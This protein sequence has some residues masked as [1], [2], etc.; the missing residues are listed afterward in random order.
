METVSKV[1]EQINHYVWGLPTFVVT[2]LV[3]VSFLT[4]RFKK[5]LQF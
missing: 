1:L 3:L 4:V 2:R 5:V